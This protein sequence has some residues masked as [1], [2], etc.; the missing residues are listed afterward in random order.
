MRYAINQWLARFSLR[1]VLIVPFILLIIGSVGITELIWFQAG[2]TAIQ[3]VS[4]RLRKEITARITEKLES[5]LETA[6]EINR[7]NTDVFT[8]DLLAVDDPANLQR[9]FLEQLKHFETIGLVAVGT[10][11]GEYSE[12]QRNSAQHLHVALAGKI[13]RGALQIWNVNH[14]GFPTEMVLSRPNYDPRE[15]RWYQT[16]VERG[17]GGW[18]EVYT[19]FSDQLTLAATQP[20]YNQYDELIAVASTN[21]KLSQINHFLSTLDV[22]DKGK[23]YIMDRTGLLIAASTN[24]PLV[25]MTTDSNEA[26]RILATDSADLII[27]ES[28]DYLKSE[29]GTLDNIQ[30]SYQLN[31]DLETDLVYLQV[32]PY[33]DERGIDWLIVVAIPAEN[34]MAHIWSNMNYMRFLS[35]LMLIVAVV[36]ALMITHSIADPILRLNQAAKCVAKGQWGERVHL[37]R[38]DE[39]GQLA[40]SFN[41]MAQQLQTSFE[42]LKT[43]ESRYRHLFEDSKDAIIIVKPEGNIIDINT[44]GLDLLGLSQTEALQAHLDNIYVDKADRQQAV[45]ALIE[46]GYIEDFETTW[47]RAD[48]ETREVSITAMARKDEDG[49]ALVFRGIIRDITER[50][51]TEQVLARYQESLE[52]IVQ[53]RTTELKTANQTL[54]QRV[55]ELEL[56]NT[57]TQAAVSATSVETMLS[58]VAEKMATLFSTI[59]C[60][61]VLFNDDKTEATIV[62]EYL[63][64]SSNVGFT[65]PIKTDDSTQQVV[66]S[67]KPFLIE[68]VRTN[69][70]TQPIHP[71]MQQL[72][73]RD[74]LLIPLIVRDEVIGTIGLDIIDEYRI[75][76]KGEI[77][78][79]ET[80][81]G[82]ISG[83]VQT[84]RLFEQLSRLNERLQAENLRL[85]AEVDITRR[86]QAMLLPSETELH[87]IEPLEIVGFME[88]ADE[89]GGDYYDVLQ[90]NGSIKIGIG[91]VTGHGLE[92]G[93]L[94]LMTQTAVR[95]LLTS[96]QTDPIQFMNVLNRTIYDN[97][98]RMGIDKS[99]TLALLDYPT[100]GLPGQ[101]YL[102]GQHEEL[103]VARANGLVERIDTIDLGFPIGL[104]DDI[105]PFINKTTIQLGPGDGIILYT[106]GI[107]E[108]ENSMGELYGLDRLCE[109][110][111]QNWHYPAETIKSTVIADVKDHIGNHVIY[112]DLTLLVLKQK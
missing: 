49:Q 62:A 32:T 112:D 12:A 103:I 24:Q 46:Y 100:Q 55:E 26:T 40:E 77:R 64:A 7:V 83:M 58:L 66:K 52:Q 96:N 16:A 104:D 70:I 2:E 81:A 107:P 69:P 92:S 17:A 53:E 90:H 38:D 65:F 54:R 76:T 82:Q 79:A 31:I 45:Q 23:I 87:N 63:H 27:Q 3:D 74:I 43:S 11:E 50:K 75:F 18:S 71:I 78:L 73:I 68:N 108:A 80:I 37:K 13:T 60:S 30:T 48:D 51:H 93:L 36:G 72:K 21:I 10:A 109:I 85:E 34:F 95:T 101:L 67:K 105:A 9:Y 106:D 86:I 89:V 59:R 56:L 111:S 88:P 39:V 6:H 25:D 8:L 29:F 41:S 5:Y 57:I 91:D 110:I 1:T 19:L 97:V 99:L 4:V 102:S 98:Q 61:I 94:A 47:K 33:V 15:E 28:A 22:G 20:V 84:V 35:L 44:A 14:R 42:T